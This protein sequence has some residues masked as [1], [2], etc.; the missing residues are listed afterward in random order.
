M[1]KL[2]MVKKE[3]SI[4]RRAILQVSPNG[5]LCCQVIDQGSS[6]AQATCLSRLAT[7]T[8]TSRFDGDEMFRVSCLFQIEHAS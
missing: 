1:V 8:P 5:L 7:Y 6:D 3:Q 4:R 2:N